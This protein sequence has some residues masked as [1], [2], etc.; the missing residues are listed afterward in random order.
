MESLCA[1]REAANGLNRGQISSGDW[2][3]TGPIN[4]LQL[5][6][7]YLE[8]IDARWRRSYDVFADLNGNL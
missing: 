2:T 6:T 3:P 8:K 7:T 4:S 1:M 5:G